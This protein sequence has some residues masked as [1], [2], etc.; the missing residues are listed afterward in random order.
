MLRKVATNEEDSGEV[1]VQTGKKNDIKDE[2]VS[3]VFLLLS[4]WEKSLLLFS[5]TFPHV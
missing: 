4:L 1:F 5:V 3:V 2:I